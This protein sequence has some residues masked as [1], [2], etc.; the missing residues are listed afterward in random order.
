M[1]RALSLLLTVSMIL[2]L[3]MTVPV[4]AAGNTPSDI[5]GAANAAVD[6]S[7]F[8]DVK[9]HWAESRLKWAVDNGLMVGTSTTKMSPNSHITRAQVAAMVTRA[10]GATKTADVSM[11]VD[12]KSGEWYY[13]SVAQALQMGCL[14]TFG[15]AINPNEAVSRQEVAVMLVKAAGY[16]LVENPAVV[17][18]Q[19]S[20]GG[21]VSDTY[22]DYFATAIANKLISGYGDGRCGPTDKITRAQFATIMQSVAKAYMTK[23]ITYSSKTVD[24]SLMVG[25]GGIKLAGMSVSKNLFLTD[26]IDSSPIVIDGTTVGGT[27]FVRGT[28]GDGVHIVN[29][30]KIGAVVF[31]NPNNAVKLTVDE[32]SSVG[33]VHVQ[34]G[35]DHV[36]LTGNVGDVYVNTGKV[37]V[38]LIKADVDDLVLNAKLC[39]VS[40]DKDSDIGTVTLRSVA[41]GSTVEVDGAIGKLSMDAKDAT[42]T[43]NGSLNSLDFGA[44]ATG[45]KFKVGKSANMKTV[46]LSA[47]DLD[48][49]L[50]GKI[51]DVDIN[52]DDSKV[53]FDRDY[54]GNT[55]EINGNDDEIILSSGATVKNIYIDGND[56]ELSGKGEV[57]KRITV[58]G[59]KRI[60]I[61]IPNAVVYNKGG[62]DVYVGDVRVR[63]GSTV[64]VNSSGT[65]TVED[66]IENGGGTNNGGNNNNGGGSGSANG[67]K[68]W[69]ITL[70]PSG[71]SVSSRTLKTDSSGAVPILPDATRTGYTFLGWFTS[72][73]GGNKIVQGSVISSHLTL[74]AQWKLNSGTTD[75]GNPDPDDPNNPSNP[76]GNPITPVVNMMLPVDGQPSDFG[77]NSAYNYAM[78]GTGLALDENY[79]LTGTVKEIKGFKWYDG[80]DGYYVPILFQSTVTNAIGVMNVGDKKF[81]VGDLVST[82]TGYNGQII[83]YLSLNPL[84]TD[85]KVTIVFDADD[86]GNAYLP[87]TLTVD[88]SEVLFL[89]EESDNMVYD[90]I[91]PMPGVD[92]AET[93]TI[94]KNKNGSCDYSLRLTTNNL[95]ESKK[96]GRFGYWVGIRIPAYSDCSSVDVKST[97]P[98]GQS[99]TNFYSVVQADDGSRYVE[100]VTDATN[101]KLGEDAAKGIYKLELTWK[102]L[103]GEVSSHSVGKLSIDL[104]GCKLAGEDGE[105]EGTTPC[106]NSLSFAVP[107]RD[108]YNAN[109][110][111]LSGVSYEDFGLDLKM[112]Q[113]TVSGQ[114]FP[115]DVKGDGKYAYYL[116]IKITG[117]AATGA[118]GEIAV[119]REAGG[120]VSAE[121]VTAGADGSFTIYALLQ[122]LDEGNSV[123]DTKITFN[124]KPTNSK[125]SAVSQVIRCDSATSTR[126]Q[127]VV[128]EDVP[129]GSIE[130]QVVTSC[131]T[132]TGYRVLFNSLNF[133]ENTTVKKLSNVSLYGKQ[134]TSVWAVPVKLRAIMG[135]QDDY[136]VRCVYYDY[137]TGSGDGK[138]TLWE[139]S[140]DEFVAANGNVLIPVAAGDKSFGGVDITLVPVGAAGDSAVGSVMIWLDSGVNLDGFDP[141][142]SGPDTPDLPA[143]PTGEKVLQS[144]VVK[145]PPTKLE[146][147]SGDTLDL[148]GLV[149]EAT[150]EVDSSTNAK[151]ITD[152]TTSPA[153]GDALSADGLQ[154]GENSKDITVEVSYEYE[155]VTKTTSFTITVK[156]TVGSGSEELP[157]D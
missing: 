30:S 80:A 145:T 23:T 71:G 70:V 114:L 35:K 43:I 33:A 104:L 112:T 110:T 142:G 57:S 16:P 137:S 50:N 86:T 8:R 150:Y 76:G 89:G 130:G 61:S 74:Y 44:N 68:G 7:K 99:S 78:F 103:D 101:K 132:T 126:G 90:G 5:P 42:V 106:V 122:L 92:G 49:A 119:T 139:L 24:G 81:S 36:Y 116:P 156:A 146:Y 54:D 34:D 147:E 32:S 40:G 77:Q 46:T 135:A 28:G 58:E 124:L 79:K 14:E 53:E 107:T 123:S 100:W 17:L 140:K 22:R 84:A 97:A 73:S 65:G 47:D 15:N 69:T 63:K 52:S 11:Y 144:I 85:K 21:S 129:T 56:I 13:D 121:A 67:G 102:T 115:V 82:G 55:I 118:T 113:E 6:F 27:V 151:A 128:S 152:Y 45:T 31:T 94:T 37:P 1:K 75:P 105:P 125:Y 48:L 138:Q 133:N 148:S 60:D 41:A 62:E 108:E 134:Y 120:S 9:G 38:Q 51:S 96:E 29:G 87:V 155:G 26:G 10:F 109:Y 66:D 111:S 95:L 59:G 64:T 20:D 131:I 2:S 4:S 18:A 93:P 88:Y 127:L 149:I 72:V 39:K 19:F 143:P 3:I 153:A 91:I 117:K 12:V 157:E 25:L 136:I 83:T 98:N 141:G 154:L